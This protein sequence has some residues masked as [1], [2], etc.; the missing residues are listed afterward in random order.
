[1]IPVL[2]LH[3]VR[4]HEVQ[5]VVARF[6]EDWIGNGLFLDVI[7]GNSMQMFIEAS[8]VIE[9]YGLEYYTGLPDHPGRIRI[10]MYD[11]FH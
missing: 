8:S 9:Q 11:D 6:I 4:H 7:T 1:V 10:V 3:G 5:N 2:D